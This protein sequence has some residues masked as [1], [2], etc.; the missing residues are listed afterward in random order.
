MLAESQTLTAV[1]PVGGG[2]SLDKIERIAMERAGV[3]DRAK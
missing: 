2:S 3:G 1:L